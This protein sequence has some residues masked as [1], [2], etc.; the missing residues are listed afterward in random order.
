MKRQSSRVSVSGPHVVSEIIESEAIIIDLDSGNYYSLQD[1]G[2][3]IWAGVQD[4]IQIEEIV[5]RL[6]M[7]YKGDEGA[8][9]SAA[10]ALLN[11]LENEALIKS[12]G[13]A[14]GTGTPSAPIPNAGPSS[15]ISFSA[16]VLRKYTDM[17][18]LLLVDP[19]HEVD[20]SGW[21][22]LPADDRELGE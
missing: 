17:Q 18:D 9:C 16:P 11:Q 5:D 12:D 15:K 14:A 2:A 3:D 6:R 20:A 22:K 4:G 19:I 13:A 8:I 7:K 21:P 1:A 10:M